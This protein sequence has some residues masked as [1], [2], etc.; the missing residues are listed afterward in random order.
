MAAVSEVK[1]LNETLDLCLRI[2]E[3]L[4]ASGAG[5]AD[6]ATTMYAVGHHLGMR[7]PDVDVTFTALSMSY[8]R[9][10][11]E[12]AL[13][14]LRQVTYRTIDYGHLT[15]VDLLV[16]DILADRVGLAGA[17]ARL[18]RIVSTGH[19]SPRWLVT[20]AWGV[21]CAGVTLFLGGGPFVI[22]I[23]VAAAVAIDRVQLVMR[24]R[25]WPFFY[26]QVAGGLVATAFAVA[27][28]VTKADVDPSLVVSSNI[29]MLLAGIGFLGAIQDALSGFYLTASGR[30][31]EAMLATAGIIA[32]VSAG[33][34]L[35]TGLGLGMGRLEPGLTGW[36]TIPATMVGAAICAAAFAYASYVPGRA[37]L[38]IAAIA[39]VAT[40]AYRLVEE[41]GFSRAW[42]A[43]VGAVVVGLVSYSVAGR[44]RVPPLVV[45]VTAVVPMLPGLSIYRGLSLLA[46]G[47]PAASSAGL[48]ALVSAAS[49]AIALSAGVI[50][51]EYVAQPLKREARRVERRL[52]G[53]LLVGARRN[54]G[55]TGPRRRTR[56]RDRW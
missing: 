40:L 46:E 44:V 8:R 35:A 18:A 27:A 55:P 5:A 16:A 14:Q 54:A 12:P 26:V 45:V 51:G 36:E 42:A 31:L 52:A 38:P 1:A 4:M 29:V 22:A 48:L 33:L 3:L 20:I 47:G 53:P 34:A 17:R 7:N 2:G 21:M 10:T 41:N 30:I 23:A 6:V 19:A 24:R 32:G 15:K 37:L 39:A 13:I 50:L 25:R 56:R 49:V 11:S 43:A 28:S 9:D